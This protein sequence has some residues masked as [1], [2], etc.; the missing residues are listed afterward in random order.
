MQKFAKIRRPSFS[1]SSNPNRRCSCSS[2]KE[3]AID[4]P[5]LTGVGDPGYNFG[6]QVV[7]IGKV[8]SR[9]ARSRVRDLLW[10]RRTSGANKPERVNKRE[11]DE[12]LPLFAQ[13][14]EGKF[15][16]VLLSDVDGLIPMRSCARPTKADFVMAGAPAT[17]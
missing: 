4:S 7:E 12:F 17:R 6:D 5:P 16:S 1:F 14:P 9:K 8:C 10:D 11:S 15:V 2:A 3:F 13:V